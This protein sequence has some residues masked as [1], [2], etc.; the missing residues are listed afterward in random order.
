MSL[1][2]SNHHPLPIAL[3]WNRRVD[4]WHSWTNDLLCI[5]H[6]MCT[7]P[8]TGTVMMAKVTT[9]LQNQAG[10]K[11]FLKE[12]N[13]EGFLED[14]PRQSLYRKDPFRSD[15]GGSWRPNHWQFLLFG[16]HDSLLCSW[17][18]GN[19]GNSFLASSLVICVWDL[20]KASY[21]DKTIFQSG[22]THF[23]GQFRGDVLIL[24]WS[25]QTASYGMPLH[26]INCDELQN[27]CDC[28][29]VMNHSGHEIETETDSPENGLHESCGRTAG[30]ASAL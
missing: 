5:Q 13:R 28:S 8:L 21:L 24:A 16:K 2:N 12:N 26:G 20:I 15:T 10:L 18:K 1:L 6:L 3:G 25:P 29:E 9:I 23:L 11:D 17:P 4:C 27:K 30:L 7:D 22:Q 14:L 19:S